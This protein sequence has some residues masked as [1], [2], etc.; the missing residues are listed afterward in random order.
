MRAFL[1]QA[2]NLASFDDV[3]RLETALGPD[4]LAGAMLAA[5]PGWIGIPPPRTVFPNHPAL[6][7]LM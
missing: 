1:A 6:S 3:R 7:H 2:M 4:R 5:E